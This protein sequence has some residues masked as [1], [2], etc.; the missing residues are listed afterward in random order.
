MGLS[1]RRPGAVTSIDD[2]GLEKLMRTQVQ[3]IH[4]WPGLRGDLPVF[5]D[6]ATLQATITQI[7][8]AEGLGYCSRPRW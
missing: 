3:A 5:F 4:D 2:Q 1:A 7:G 6:A 8:P